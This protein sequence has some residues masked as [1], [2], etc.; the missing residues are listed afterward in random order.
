[1]FVFRGHRK[2]GGNLRATV[3]SDCYGGGQQIYAEPESN[4]KT[5]KKRRNIYLF[6]FS[7][8]SLK[9]K[10]CMNH[11]RHVSRL[12]QGGGRLLEP[13]THS[14]SRE[15]Y[16][17]QR[18]RSGGDG[19]LSSADTND[20]TKRAQ[21]TTLQHWHTTVTATQ[22]PSDRL[23]NVHHSRTSFHRRLEDSLVVTG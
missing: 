13:S 19:G 10:K 18:R 1:M 23:I 11:I 17:V 16:S 4:K 22:G 20:D 9:S 2:D 14:R 7:F 6:L 15:K 5:V 3:V 12:E 8:A 21:L